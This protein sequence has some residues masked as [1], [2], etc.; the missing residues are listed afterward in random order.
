M[1]GSMIL[2]LRLT[3]LTMLGLAALRT[4]DQQ[5]ARS[6]IRCVLAIPPSQVAH[7]PI[8]VPVYHPP[9]LGWIAIT[10]AVECE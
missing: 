5:M 3:V 4:P 7:T 9:P 6:T 10:D 1:A 2:M 8:V